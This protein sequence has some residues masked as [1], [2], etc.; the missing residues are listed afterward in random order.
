[1]ESHCSFTWHL[2]DDEYQLC[3]NESL[4]I[5]VVDRPYYLIWWIISDLMPELTSTCEIMAKLAC[6]ASLLKAHYYRLKSKSF[7]H[8][9]AM[10][11]T[12]VSKKIQTILS[13]NVL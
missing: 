4:M 13:C 8:N 3:M 1:M 9:C 12:S 6:N 10:L 11:A 2:K 7:S 5:R